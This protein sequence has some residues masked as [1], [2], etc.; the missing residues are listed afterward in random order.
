MPQSKRS[1]MHHNVG[2][3]KSLFSTHPA[4]RSLKTCES[5]AVLIMILLVLSGDAT[6]LLALSRS[7]TTTHF[8]LSIFCRYGHSGG[9]R[10]RRLPAANVA[11]FAVCKGTMDCNVASPMRAAVGM[12]AI[13]STWF[14]PQDYSLPIIVA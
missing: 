10:R 13:I 11:E 7:C 3:S 5:M 9:G 2:H 6:A 4:M 12:S 8:V 1:L 14:S